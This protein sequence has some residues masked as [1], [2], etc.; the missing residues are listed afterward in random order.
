MTVGIVGLGLIGGSMAQA[1]KAFTGHRVYGLDRDG[2]VLERA[3][4]EGV[5][6]G[7]L[8]REALERCDVLLLALYPKAAVEYV[9]RHGEHIPA[10]ACVVDLCG[11]K[12]AVWEG[13]GPMA[14]QRGF[15]YVGGHPM[16][17]RELSGYGAAKAELF[18]GASMLLCPREGE[19]PETMAML[20]EFFRALGFARV[21]LTTPREHDR[22]IAYTS[23]LAHVLS[24]AYV[25]SP[26]AL[27]S[28]RFSGGSFQDLT[29]VARLNVPMWTEL[30][31]LNR[32][33][34]AQEID[35]L[36]GRLS[37]Y[38]DALRAQDGE[39]LA[40]L[41]QEGCDWKARIGQ[42]EGGKA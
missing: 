33:L 5:L 24:N 17:G 26:S 25:K 1:V 27:D 28:G 38:G 20:K 35:G 39:R 40:A 16:A 23:Q 11:V 34:L 36:C 3:L 14:A 10:G 18:A 12:R 9:A 29:R 30:F 22:I 37:A 6:D 42:G 31:L 2:A 15:C 7:E 13:I 21:S 19:T 41:L 4:A 32:D 8:N